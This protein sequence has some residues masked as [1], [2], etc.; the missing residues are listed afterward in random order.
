M[1]SILWGGA[2]VFGL[3]GVGQFV[4]GG[5]LGWLVVFGATGFYSGAAALGR[6]PRNVAISWSVLWALAATALLGLLGPDA[7]TGG[8]AVVG[9][10]LVVTAWSAFLAW[11]VPAET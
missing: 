7:G 8:L 10:L 2:V 9:C 11:A 3:L 4:A 6:L 1:T 5:S